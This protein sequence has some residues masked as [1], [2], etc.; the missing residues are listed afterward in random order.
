MKT[1]YFLSLGF[2]ILILGC[3]S[4][5]AV[6]PLEPAVV[7]MPQVPVTVAEAPTYTPE[8]IREGKT[9]YEN[10]CGKCHMLFATTDYKKEDWD[11]I[12]KRMQPKAKLDDFAIEQI[13]TYIHSTLN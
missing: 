4:K 3:A 7:L 5:T 8:N 9:L 6:K 2:S 1:F 13:R 12:L 11:P 10:S